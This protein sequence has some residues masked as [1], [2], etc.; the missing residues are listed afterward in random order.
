MLTGSLFAQVIHDVEFVEVIAELKLP[1]R[2]KSK[3]YVAKSWIEHDCG[4][5]WRRRRIFRGCLEDKADLGFLVDILVTIAIDG[6][7]P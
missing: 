6:T 7:L 2:N 3:P 4:G 5:N 1:S